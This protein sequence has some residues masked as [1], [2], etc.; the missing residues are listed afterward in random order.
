MSVNDAVIKEIRLIH[1]K[2]HCTFEY[3][4]KGDGIGGEDKEES[5]ASE[6]EESYE[7]FVGHIMFVEP[8]VEVFQT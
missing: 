5:K 2:R 8:V 7:C 3:A 1:H 6:E 4:F